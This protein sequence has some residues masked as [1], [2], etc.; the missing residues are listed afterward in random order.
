MSGAPW[1][2]ADLAG[3]LAQDAGM[4]A[5]QF[6]RETGIRPRQGA[7]LARDAAVSDAEFAAQ[8][9]TGP[10]SSISLAA[11]APPPD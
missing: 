11:A 5:E 3:H 8:T 9:G 2:D 1:Y 4:T 7:D 10:E 6:E